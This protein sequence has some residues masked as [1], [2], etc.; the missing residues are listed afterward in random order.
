L[1][2]TIRCASRR[3]EWHESGSTPALCV[4]CNACKARGA[5]RPTGEVWRRALMRRSAQ[6]LNPRAAAIRVF[7][8][9]AGLAYRPTSAWCGTGLAE[10]CIIAPGTCSIVQASDDTNS[11]RLL[12]VFDDGFGIRTNSANGP[13]TICG[14]CQEVPVIRSLPFADA[15]SN[16]EISNKKQV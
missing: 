8:R 3:R 14:S 16:M 11:Q 2:P 5:E 12:W 15:A 1:Q 4:L 7:Q 6:T 9:A 10:R 13:I